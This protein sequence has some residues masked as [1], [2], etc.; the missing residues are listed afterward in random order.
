M[1]VGV[2]DAE[3]ALGRRR[4]DQVV[5]GGEATTTSQLA[6]RAES[7]AADGSSYGCLRKR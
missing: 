2:E 7:G 5:G 1:T 3:A 6:C 4:G